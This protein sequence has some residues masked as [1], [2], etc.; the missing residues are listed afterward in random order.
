MF[1]VYYDIIISIKKK[2]YV[3]LYVDLSHSGDWYQISLSTGILSARELMISAR[4]I[5]ARSNHFYP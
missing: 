2:I 1:L 5:V 4:E 3:N